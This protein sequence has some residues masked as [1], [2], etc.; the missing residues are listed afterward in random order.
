MR[1]AG[2]G[3]RP[4][5]GWNGL[6]PHPINGRG[7]IDAQFFALWQ[8]TPLADAYLGQARRIARRRLQARTA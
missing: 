1:D 3:E 4:P 8:A 2:V 7:G 6:F 5:A